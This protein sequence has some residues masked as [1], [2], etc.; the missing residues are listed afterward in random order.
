MSGGVACSPGEVVGLGTRE[1]VGT[2]VVVV[3][4]GGT[5]RVSQFK[6]PSPLSLLSSPTSPHSLSCPTE[7][8]ST[9]RSHVK[10]F[11]AHNGFVN[12]E[13]TFRANP[14]LREVHEELVGLYREVIGSTKLDE[15]MLAAQRSGSAALQELMDYGASSHRYTRLRALFDRDLAAWRA[16]PEE[17]KWKKWSSLTALR[18]MHCS[19][20]CQRFGEA[21]L[22][23]AN[24]GE[25]G[26][27]YE[28][29][30]LYNEKTR[31]FRCAECRRITEMPDVAAFREIRVAEEARPR[32][33]HNDEHCG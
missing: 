32:R 13:A 25:R 11:Y 14:G 9:P 16:A 18:V 20:A 10:I 29:T 19:D 24:L 6:L 22:R 4:G 1:V 5:E 33:N 8:M 2:G 28:L 21:G 23:T 7:D 17:P 31:Q 27:G 3:D 12:Y 30:V 15:A 26:A